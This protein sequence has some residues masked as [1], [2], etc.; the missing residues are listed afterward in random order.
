MSGR[1]RTA[2]SRRPRLAALAAWVL[3]MSVAL[4]ATR[5]EIR[6]PS[7]VPAADAAGFKEFSDGVTAY[8]KLQ[9]TIESRLP[10]LKT[11]D[12][13][14]MIA[15][16]QLALARK[17]R[18]ARPHAKVGDL[19]TPGASDAFRHASHTAL[20]GPPGANS[21]DYMQPGAADV[22]MRLSVNGTYPDIGSITP[23]PPAL[24]AAFPPLPVDVA[25][26]V[27]GRTLIL[28]DLKSR[29]VVDFS[30]LIL[31]PP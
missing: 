13:P 12:L 10:S 21:R 4:V 16:H 20:D 23:L 18:E 2:R 3:G 28:V 19:F 26:R 30:R 22:S 6:L 29:L 1:Q 9:R 8:L 11:T 25:Y 24:L 5:D 14:E 31:S 7:Q 15:A 27:V 17:I